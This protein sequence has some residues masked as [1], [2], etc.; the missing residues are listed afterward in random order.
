MPTATPALDPAATS[1][2]PVPAPV[3]E[4]P[5]W[6]GKADVAA[7]IHP[8][9]ARAL[10]EW[11]LGSGFDPVQDANRINTPAGAGHFLL[12]PS[13]LGPWSG[14]KVLSVA[15]DN[16]A[17]GFPRIQATYVLMDALTLTTRALMDGSLLTELRTPA[18]SAVAADRLAA[19]DASQLL[20]FG[21]GPQALAH[22]EAMAAIRPLRKVTVVGRSPG[23]VAIALAKAT[24]LGLEAVRGD[25]AAAA[26]ADIIVCATSA[27]DPLFD[28]SQV[29]DG[30]CVIAMGS[31]ETDRRELDAGL[32]GRSLV[33]VEDTA[34][35]LREAGDVTL[36]IAEGTLDGGTLVPLLEI[37]RGTAVRRSDAP[38]VFKSVGMSWQDLA[39]AIGVVDPGIGS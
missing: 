5:L 23:K 21:T 34:T 8:K 38:N 19:P 11:A 22:I 32:L 18:V 3:P 37:V 14:I 28:G 24:E 10:I 2:F 4:A 7:R 26:D 39:V 20:V 17:I 25:A 9:R 29:K 16:P 35:A 12:M 36:A 33:V 1:P 13:T 30:A 31:H 27:K 15:P 6:F